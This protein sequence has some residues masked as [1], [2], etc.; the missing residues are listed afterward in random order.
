MLSS[1]SVIVPI[2]QGSLRVRGKNLRPFP[3]SKIGAPGSGSLLSWKLDQLKQIFPVENIIVS[4]DWDLALELASSYGVTTDDRPR[5]LAEA[6]SP[7]EKL[8]SHCAQLVTTPYMAWAPATSPFCGVDTM[9]SMVSVFSKLSEKDKGDGLIAVS[10]ESSYFFMGGQPLNFPVGMGHVRTQDIQALM[11]LNWAFCLRTADDVMQHS[12]MFSGSPNF[13]E[14]DKLANLDINE[15]LDFELAT[16][17][18][19]LF[20]SRTQH[21]E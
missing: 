5:W 3:N 1:T 19:Q 20:L 9:S 7:F 2:R 21:A 15:E 11:I 18:S 4:S 6:D 17:L 13:F 12:Y 8:I 10:K 16:S 14:I